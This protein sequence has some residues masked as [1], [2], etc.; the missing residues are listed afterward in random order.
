MSVSLKNFSNL[1][2]LKVWKIFDYCLSFS[3]TYMPEN[4][5][6]IFLFQRLISLSNNKNIRLLSLVSTKYHRSSA[7][8]KHRRE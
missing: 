6:E 4:I 1:Y 7:Q 8:N 5:A 2:A 3:P